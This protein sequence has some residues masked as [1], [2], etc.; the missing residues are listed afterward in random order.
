[1]LIKNE[2]L[3]DKDCPYLLFQ[4][5]KEMELEELIAWAKRYRCCSRCKRIVLVHAGIKDLDNYQMHYNFF[6]RHQ[7]SVNVLQELFLEHKAKIAVVEDFVEINCEED[8]W[9]I[10]LKLVHGR[11]ELLHNNY[12]REFDGKRS[13]GEGYHQQK[14]P[15]KSVQSALRY[16]MGYDYELF[17]G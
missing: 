6:D 10:P 9:R 12:I 14:L 17:H 8:T 15:R 5:D 3:H 2:I 4:G 7:V 1:M 16:I 11:V 13:I